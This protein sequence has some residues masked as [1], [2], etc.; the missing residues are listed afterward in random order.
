MSRPRSSRAAARTSCA[1]L[2][3]F[4]G[5]VSGAL[6]KQSRLGI[7]H[8]VLQATEPR[9]PA[10][11]GPCSTCIS[12]GCGCNPSPGE[13]PCICKVGDNT[14]SSTSSERRS[15][16]DRIELDIARRRALLEARRRENARLYAL[17]LERVKKKE[18]KGLQDANNEIKELEEKTGHSVPSESAIRTAESDLGQAETEL[19]EAKGNIE[20][21]NR[22]TTEASPIAG[23][24]SVDGTD[25]GDGAAFH[26]RTDASK[27]ALSIASK[28]SGG[29]GG[30]QA[31]RMVQNPCDPATI[32]SVWRSS[33][34]QNTIT[35]HVLSMFTA[36]TGHFPNGTALQRNPLR[37]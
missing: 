12:R 26:S 8:G 16:R 37:R 6:S 11:S 31:V 28:S 21:M 27:E 35:S 22:Q 7:W 30:G 2:V 34:H 36:C 13:E 25:P 18:T 9:P 15:D 23:Q 3:F 17:A 10:S 5:F 1:C 24:E 14:P 32:S 33:V 4:L 29:A 19:V 20:D